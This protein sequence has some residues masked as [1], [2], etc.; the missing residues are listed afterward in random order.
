MLFMNEYEIDEAVSYWQNHP[1]LGPASKL[2]AALRDI[3]NQNSDGWAYWSPPVRAAKML[4]ELLQAARRGEQVTETEFK[5]ALPPIKR[6]YSR[7]RP[8][9]TNG[10]PLRF[11]PDQ[12]L[13]PECLKGL[14]EHAR[15]VGRKLYCRDCHE[16]Q[17]RRHLREGLVGQDAHAANGHVNRNRHKTY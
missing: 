12:L 4:Q 3:V 13:C 14:D 16:D 5:K 11:P 9:L 2:L 6:F 17:Q 8:Q 1:L 7:Y 15:R 10:D